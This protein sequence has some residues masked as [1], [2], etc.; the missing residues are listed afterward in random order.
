LKNVLKTISLVILLSISVCSYGEEVNI[1]YTK[2]GV[3]ESISP[4]VKAI[5]V[6]SDSK[7]TLRQDKDLRSCDLND[8]TKTDNLTKT[9]NFFLCKGF[10]SFQAHAIA[11]NFMR[12]S[13]NGR[14]NLL[15]DPHNSSGSQY[16]I[17]QWTGGRKILFYK[18]FGHSLN[19][20]SLQEQLEFVIYEFKNGSSLEKLSYNKII[21]SNNFDSASSAFVR[22]YERSLHQNKDISRN[23][24]LYKKYILS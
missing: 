21:S 19:K 10:K 24:E 1:D 13:M 11:A 8:K 2:D 15:I 7:Q 4:K 5:V 3:E 6:Q 17:A 16:G 9:I 14:K 23:R 18:K 20:S 12:E 22:L